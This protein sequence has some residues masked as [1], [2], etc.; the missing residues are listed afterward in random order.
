MSILKNCKKLKNIRFSIYEDF[1]LKTTA[2][3]KEK[4]QEVLAYREKG[5][6][7]LNYIT[8]KCKQRIR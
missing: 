5:I 8:V 4:W 7:Y 2:I 6:S 1:P 3:R